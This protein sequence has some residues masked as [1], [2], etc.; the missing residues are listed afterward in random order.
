MTSRAGLAAGLALAAVLTFA[1]G[2][3]ARHAIGMPFASLLL[4]PFAIFSPVSL[5]SWQTERLGVEHYDRVVQIDGERVDARVTWGDLPSTRV[6]RILASRHAAGVPHAR[7]VFARAQGTFTI[8]A[9]LR[10]IDGGAVGAYFVLYALMG[11]LILWSGVAVG[12]LGARRE[13]ARAYRFMA[14]WG[15]V[16]LVTFFDY[17]TTAAL[18]PFF[19]LATVGVPFGLAWLAWAFPEP[20]RAPPPWTR[21]GLRVATALASCIAFGLIAGPAAGWDPFPLRRMVD[22]FVPA[23]L[24]VLAASV[25]LRL[26]RSRGSERDELR[27]VIWGMA[28]LPACVGAGFA[29][30]LLSGLVVFHIALPFVAFLIPLSIG[31]ALVRHNIL[32]THAVLGRRLLIVPTVLLALAVALLAWL[33]LRSDSPRLMDALLPVVASCG[34]FAAVFAALYRL[35]NRTLF[36]AAAEFRPTIQQLAET[37]GDLDSRDDL[38]VALERIIARWL[39]S[40]R[41]RLLAPDAL[42]EIDHLPPDARG[43]LDSGHRV[44]TNASPWERHLLVP[45]RSLGVLRAV[46]DIAPKHQGALFTEEDLAL[47]DT[48]AALGA[49]ALH[50]AETMAALDATRQLELKATREDKRLTLGLLGAELAHEIAH[51]L[52]FFQ[53]ILRRGAKRPLD[54]EDVEIGQEEIARMERMLAQFRRLESPPP[55]SVPVALAEPV[56]RALVLVREALSDKTVTH[57]V[58]LPPGAVV[59][60]DP[61][62][63]VQ[64]FANLLRNAAQAVEPRGHVG[65]RGTLRDDG[66]LV[67]DVWDEGPGVPADRVGTLFHRWV[68]S[69]AHEGGTGLGLSVAQSLVT[70]FGWTIE[71]VREP[72]RTC[73]RV[74]VPPEKV[75]PPRGE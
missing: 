51:P 71:Y 39:P 46:I 9:P 61:D 25:F 4:D 34:V 43:H 57:A 20:P 18:V 42:D 11:L 52:R 64:V 48:I 60:G 17:H 32:G 72:A 2:H 22:V 31:W 12:L 63:L 73:F 10:V 6:T 1:A 59:W 40:G 38:R 44:W 28:A 29:I 67:I 19:S 75:C 8:D 68:T 33:A 47:L 56:A 55:R 37:L 27:A 16:F 41:V 5:P 49:I 70:D 62:G 13:G 58:D 66:A 35:V 74:T 69:R 21:P 65:V 50:N 14:L 24:L 7:L 15:F 30:N 54:P 26:R 45:V 53:G 36:P 3:N 23:S